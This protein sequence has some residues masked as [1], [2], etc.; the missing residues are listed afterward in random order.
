M[1]SG[2]NRLYMIRGVT[3]RPA[4]A[5]TTEACRGWAYRQGRGRVWGGD[6]GMGRRG[7]NRWLRGPRQ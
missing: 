7:Q 3:S 6:Q 2:A 4:R 1:I 5:G